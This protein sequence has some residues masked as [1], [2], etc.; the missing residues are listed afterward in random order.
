MDMSGLYGV[1]DTSYARTNQDTLRWASVAIAA[2]LFLCCLISGVVI[3][4]KPKFKSDLEAADQK[5]LTTA[6]ATELSSDSTIVKLV[7]VAFFWL[8]TLVSTFLSWYIASLHMQKN[9]LIALDVINV[10]IFIMLGLAAYFYYKDPP[11]Q[12]GISRMLVGSSAVLEFIV[13]I[14]LLVS[15]TAAG[16]NGQLTSSALYVPLF[17]S[18]LALMWR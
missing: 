8:V 6:A 10:V 4:T 5:A 9:N 12:A 11:N 18:T 3:Y 15:T 7:V 2:V 1:F 14:V 13:L 16:S 17:I